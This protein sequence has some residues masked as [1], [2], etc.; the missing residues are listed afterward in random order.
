MGEG[1]GKA[2]SQGMNITDRGDGM[3]SKAWGRQVLGV[4]VPRA[5]KGAKGRGG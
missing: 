3:S 4:C 1:G 2:D 5:S